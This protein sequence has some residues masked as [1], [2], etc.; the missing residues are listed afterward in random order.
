MTPTCRITVNG[1]LVSGVFMRRVISCTV[2]DK[3][4]GASDT[5]DILL[6]DYPFAAIPQEKDIIRVWMGYGVAGMGYFGAFTLEEVELQ[7]FPFRMA[8]RGKAADQAGKGKENKERHWD[9]PTLKK[10]VSQ[11]AGE[12]GLTPV[13][14]AAL[15]AFKFDW[16]GQ[17]DESDFHFLERLARRLGGLYTEKDGKLIFAKRG[18]GL[19]AL[20]AALTGITITPEVLQP[21]SARIRFSG[22]SKYKDVKA[23]YTD[24]DTR[25]K[26]DVSEPSAED[27]EAVYRIGEPFADEAEAKQAAKAKADELKR[28][29]LKMSATIVGNPAARAGAPASFAG[30]RPGIDGLPFILETATHRFSKSGYLTGVEGGMGGGGGGSGEAGGGAGTGSPPSQQPGGSLDNIDVP[31][32]FGGA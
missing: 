20:G 26:V 19:S 24:K 16:L 30:C 17:Q 23:S 25:K 15:G 9:E 31:L 3:E 28:R 14:D 27:G 1:A 12:R 11:I 29:T 21:N 2:T 32:N 10:V 4:G 5:V 8:I 22:R 13:I 7:L 6:N 18:S